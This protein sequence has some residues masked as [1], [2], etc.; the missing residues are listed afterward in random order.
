MGLSDSV[1]EVRERVAW[2]CEAS[3]RDPESVRLVA[4]TKTVD[5]DVIGTAIECG[6][7]DFGEN[8]V[9]EARS[10]I[11]LV[12][13][14]RWHFIGNLQSNKA[15]VAAADYSTPSTVLTTLKSPVVWG[16]REIRWR[17]R[18]RP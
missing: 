10:K 5:A 1:R 7:E 6:I 18:L 9:Q 11:P 8:R 4:V 2:A 15:K 16:R 14:G 17:I 3:R 13:T 12:N